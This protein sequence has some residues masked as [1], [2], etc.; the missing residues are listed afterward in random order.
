M[1]SALLT[2]ALVDLI[3][4]EAKSESI[5]SFADCKLY[6]SNITWSWIKKTDANVAKVDIDKVTLGVLIFKQTETAP[7]I[8]EVT[9]LIKKVKISRERRPPLC[10]VVHGTGSPTLCI[11]A[12]D[13]SV[14]NKGQ[15]ANFALI[16]RWASTVVGVPS[17][18]VKIV[19]DPELGQTVVLPARQQQLLESLTQA[20]QT[21]GCLWTG[22]VYTVKNDFKANL[23]ELL[24]AMRLLNEHTTYLRKRSD[25]RT[26]KFSQVSIQDLK[27]LYNVKAGLEG[28]RD[29]WSLRFITEI[30]AYAIRPTNKHFP[31]TAVHSL[32][33]RNSVTTNEGLFAKMGWTPKAPDTHKLFSVL[34]N[35]VA[36]K[37]DTE[38]VEIQPLPKDAKF[39]YI[40][41]RAAVA[42]VLPRLSV[43]SASPMN[44]QILVDPLAIAS[45]SI[46]KTYSTKEYVAYV[47][48]INLAF[49]IK[50]ARN[51]PNS[52]A[53]A[54]QFYTARQHVLRQSS[55]IPLKDGDGN[56]YANENAIPDQ[57]REYLK[58]RFPYEGPSPIK[59]SREENE[60]AHEASIVE[61]EKVAEA[62][63]SATQVPDVQ[64]SEAVSTVTGPITKKLKGEPAASWE[65]D[66][67]AAKRRLRDPRVQSAVARVNVQQG[68]V[69]GAGL[70]ER[71]QSKARKRRG[72]VTS[73][74][75]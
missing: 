9:N 75:G 2:D 39:K 54:E 43:K 28:A 22:E 23:P 64:M 48:A 20:Y 59:R 50:M 29:N 49:A 31:G 65:A 4:V 7:A 19:Y 26:N 51:R 42:A 63:T 55:K 60:A 10:V 24:A 18:Q 17:D 66:L 37:G 71:Q 16:I 41:H 62:S 6:C 13:I 40:E 44:K 34:Y 68:T 53:T 67:A 30:L 58:G 25:T 56:S 61:F 69:P 45:E 27:E 70:S 8:E 35:V 21:T 11:R 14:E 73:K 33:V 5:V 74:R 47:D 32:R 3:C 72:L 15:V 52:K 12:P 46:I 38:R 1:Q 36:E 57:I